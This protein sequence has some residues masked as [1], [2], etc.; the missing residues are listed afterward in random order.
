[1]RTV[2]DEVHKFSFCQPDQI[3]I[4]QKYCTAQKKKTDTHSFHIPSDILP[5]NNYEIRKDSHQICILCFVFL[6]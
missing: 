3:L 1:M 2:A 5:V 6:H 4:E